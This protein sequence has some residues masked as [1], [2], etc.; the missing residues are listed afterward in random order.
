M[1][2]SIEFLL[3]RAPRLFYSTCFTTIKSKNEGRVMVTV[4]TGA[5]VRRGLRSKMKG[6]NGA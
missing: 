1:K 2:P 6:E 3:N 5:G 4:G